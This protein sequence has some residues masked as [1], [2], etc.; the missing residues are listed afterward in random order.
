[1]DHGTRV[2][3]G[4]PVRREAR[5]DQVGRVRAPRPRARRGFALS[6]TTG[7]F[8]SSTALSHFVQT[9][10]RIISNDCECTNTLA[11]NPGRLSSNSHLPTLFLLTQR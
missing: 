1:M 5:D 6:G 8:T 7:R 2:Q 10:K 11:H 4:T 3:A 9:V